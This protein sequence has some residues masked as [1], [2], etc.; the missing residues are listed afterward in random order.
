LA[1]QNSI[2]LARR[3]E[4]SSIGARIKVLRKKN[5]L[6]QRELSEKIDVH[7]VTLRRWE[8]STTNTPDGTTIQA[9]A[10]ALGTSVAYLLG[11]SDFPERPDG[12]SGS[13]LGVDKLPRVRSEEEL[14]QD[15]VQELLA[16]HSRDVLVEIIKDPQKFAAASLLAAMDQD[17]LRKAYE[18]LQDQKRLGEFLKEKGA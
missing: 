12:L 17:Q 11:E 13:L 8:N 15:A 16:E 1:E 2:L 6:T 10:S 9:L 4:M 14:I 7:E 3:D 5:G 18:Y